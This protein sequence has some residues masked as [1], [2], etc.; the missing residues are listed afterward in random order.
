MSKFSNLP[1]RVD[2]I[3]FQSRKEAR[4]YTELK[5]MQGGGVIRDLELQPKFRL[6]VNGIHVCDYFAD[7]RYYDIE[8][9]R[10]VVEDAKGIRTREYVL[11]SRLMRAVHEIE[12]E[13]V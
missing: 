3:L 7:F 12:V 10:I 4:R 1:Q 5:A 2:G 9:G 11:K 8:R 13:E 6:E